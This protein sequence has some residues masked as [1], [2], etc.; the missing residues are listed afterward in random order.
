MSR[1]C[2]TFHRKRNFSHHFLVASRGEL[3]S[4]MHSFTWAKRESI[5]LNLSY[6]TTLWTA[7]LAS[8]VSSS[9]HRT[10]WKRPEAPTQKQSHQFCEWNKVD[11]TYLYVFQVLKYVWFRKWCI[12]WDLQWCWKMLQDAGPLEACL[13][14]LS[15]APHPLIHWPAVELQPLQPAIGEFILDAFAVKK[16]LFQSFSQFLNVKSY[17]HKHKHTMSHFSESQ[18]NTLRLPKACGDRTGTESISFRR[19]CTCNRATTQLCCFA[20]TV[21]PLQQFERFKHGC[22]GDRR[23]LF[24]AITVEVIV[25]P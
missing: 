5:L 17:T 22:H 13:G 11:A 9:G 2:T 21:G 6:S 3:M 19:P 15:A 4:P 7:P 24:V 14:P 23:L 18:Q 25:S 20:I 10:A 1:S 8:V 16:A 12:K